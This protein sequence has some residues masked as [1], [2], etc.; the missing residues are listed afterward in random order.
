MSP[1]QPAQLTPIEA[2]AA[3]TPLV[4]GVL[5]RVAE[6]H[7]LPLQLVANAAVTAGV[8]IAVA[9]D[10]PAAVARWLRELADG[11]DGVPGLRQ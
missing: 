4:R 6:R 2:L 5:E 9:H 1:E 8:T 10:G 11:L 7:A 3:M